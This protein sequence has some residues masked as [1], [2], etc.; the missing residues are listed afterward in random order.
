MKKLRKEFFKSLYKTKMRYLSIVLIVTLGVA[1]FAG[2]RACRPDMELSADHYFDQVDLWDLRIVSA[3]GMTKEDIHKIA[4]VPD[5]DVA[6]GAYTKEVF[7]E[8]KE[9]QLAVKVMSVQPKLNQPSIK[10]GRLPQKENECVLDTKLE[11]QGFQIGDKIQ[12]KPGDGMPLAAFLKNEEY[13]ITG[14]A[15]YPYYLSLDRHTAA[16]GNGS[17]AGFI[18]V[19]QESF[20]IRS[21]PFSSDSDELYTETFVKV[22]GA[23]KLLCYSEEY[24][25][26]VQDVQKKI[27]TLNGEWYVFDRD[28]IQ[29]YAEYGQDANRIGAI[30]E[31]F[32]LIF[33]FVA[34]LVSLTTM[35]RMVEEE[36]TQIGTL[37]ALGYT[38]LAIAAKYILYGCSAAVIGSVFGVLIGQ[39]V[40]PKVIITA[41]AILYNN[42]PEVLSP[43]QADYAFTSALVAIFC[44]TGAAMLA[45]YKEML[46]VPAQLMRPQAPKNGKRVFLERMQFVWKRLSF[47]KKATVRNLIRYKK[48]FFMT[49][50]GVG[51][52]TALLLVGFGLK[53]SVV[54]IGELQFGEV[55]LYDASILL[56]E[57]KDTTQLFQMLQEETKECMYAYETSM[58]V[59][60]GKTTK[61][62]Y[63]IVPQNEKEWSSYMNLQ[64]RKTKEKWTL[65]DDGIIITEK[66]ATLL[67]VS[68]GD[69]I[70]LKISDTDQRKVKI[71]AV[72]ENYFMHY[73]YMTPSLYRTILGQE[74]QYN[75]IFAKFDKASNAYEKEFFETFGSMDGVSNTSFTSGIAK[76]VRD[77]LKS[78]DAIIVVLV[79]SAGLLSFVV[80]FNLNNI[81]ISE[82]VRELATIKV[83]GFYDKELAWYVY[84]ENIVLTV[85]GTVLGLGLGLVLHR[86]VIS[87]AEI[88]MLMFSRF[89]KLP[90]FVYAV[91]LTFVFSMLVN[92][93]M[94][95][96]L[97]NIDMIQS[98]KSVE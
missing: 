58:D 65:S 79:V 28:S 60:N 19:P 88:D 96:K 91:V 32:P 56:D 73:I 46:L 10:K 87:T 37:K 51:G 84:R 42:L 54:S 76:R 16:I 57:T 6:E 86:F 3:S 81:N 98:L 22:N 50:F 27:E 13:T 38:K 92:G 39:H 62:S 55:C 59:A 78:M 74:P 53:D 93:M 44:T 48:R 33:F 63:L 90:S 85:I 1:F 89:I 29:T 9:E 7:C 40:L 64:D 20:C 82:R 49:I 12:L 45:C 24:E 15:T 11:Q 43:L 26:L 70:T 97:K 66:L 94:Y 69:E 47:S 71:S 95:R 80:L 77:M 23:E 2:V 30:G 61:S 17:M 21:D 25:Q 8:G 83:L 68:A 75:A 35:T 14:F 31:V 41:Y 34:A 72:S 36:R 18:L 5:V 4:S 52:C 67:D